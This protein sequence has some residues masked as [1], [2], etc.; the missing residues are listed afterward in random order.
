MSLPQNLVTIHPY[1]KLQPGRAEDAQAIMEEFVAKT[2]TEEACLFYEFT[3]N[4]DWVFCREG[5][6]GGEGVLTHLENVGSVI[7]KMLT[8]SEMPRLEF[9]GPGE[10]IDKLREPL[11]ELKPDFYVLSEGIR[12]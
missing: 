10:E 5:Y 9:H 4:G 1:F 6:V 7:E 8:I 11:A 2:K 3:I 12:R